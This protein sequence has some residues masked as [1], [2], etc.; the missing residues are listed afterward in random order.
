M[1][2]T[3]FGLP[4]IIRSDNGP[5]YNSKEFQQFLQCYSIMHQTSSPNHLRS[6]GFA[7]C[8]V[9]VAK[10]LIYKAGKERK[11]WISGLFEYRISPQEGSIASHLQLMTQCRP[12]EKNLPQLPSTLGAKEMHQTCQEL[13]RR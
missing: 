1:I 4:H 2:V 13:I 7:E 10:N 6:N 8:M 12:R 9:G 3:E 5:Y 11:P